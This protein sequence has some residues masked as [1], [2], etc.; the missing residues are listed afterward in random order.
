M[1]LGAGALK[2]EGPIPQKGSLALEV[3]MATLK[4]KN[5]QNSLFSR[6]NLTLAC[7]HFE[8]KDDRNSQNKLKNIATAN[9]CGGNKEYYDYQ[10]TFE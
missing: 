8:C 4:N 9:V 2:V 10:G 1:S 7:I 5:T 6:H 3:T